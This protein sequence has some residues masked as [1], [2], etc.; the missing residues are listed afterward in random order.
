MGTQ[1]HLSH[2][3]DQKVLA[4]SSAFLAA[5]VHVDVNDVDDGVRHSQDVVLNRLI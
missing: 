2:E 1:Q 3:E 5:A 4:M